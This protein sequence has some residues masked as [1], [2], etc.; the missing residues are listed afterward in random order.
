MSKLLILQSIKRYLKVGYYFPS[1]F[2]TWDNRLSKLKLISKNKCRVVHA[3]TI[4]Q[5][6]VIATKIWSVV[7][8]ATNLILDK[9]GSLTLWHSLTLW[10]SYPGCDRYRDNFAGSDRISVTVGTLRGLC[11]RTIS[12]LHLFHERYILT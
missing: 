2:V 5:V 11:S 1:T 12:E 6:I 10:I 7:T 8:M 4:L 9:I 3:G